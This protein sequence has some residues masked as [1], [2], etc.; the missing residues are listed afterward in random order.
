MSRRRWVLP[1]WSEVAGW[2]AQR[3]PNRVKAHIWLQAYEE[4]DKHYRAVEEVED[5]A[6]VLL[7]SVSAI[8]IENLR[9]WLFRDQ[10]KGELLAHH[11]ANEGE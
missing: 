1:F 2:V 5:D 8:Q 4:L 6:R 10:L 9:R 11:E 3:L 7:D